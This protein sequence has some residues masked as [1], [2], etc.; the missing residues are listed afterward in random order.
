VRAFYDYRR[1]T[2]NRSRPNAGHFVIA[3]LEESVS[4]VVVVTQNVDGLHEGAGSSSVFPL[5]GR[6]MEDRCHAGCAGVYPAGLHRTICP[7]CGAGSM[8][9]N[10]V[11]FGEAL[12]EEVLLRASAAVL[13]CDLFF[14]IG[15]SGLVYPAAGFV[16]LAMQRGIPVIEIN[17]EETP[18]SEKAD[19]VIRLPAAEAL[20]R[21]C[22]AL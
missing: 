1:E 2:L 20:P 10:V 8:R 18:F 19:V 16:G 9:P 15:T 13:A 12:D 11:W 21:I 6:I 4:N 14:S 7:V 3:R 5:H 22:D 17:P